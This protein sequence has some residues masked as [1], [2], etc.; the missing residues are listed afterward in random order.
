MRHLAL[1]TA[2]LLTA[3]NETGTAKVD[4]RR[5]PVPG[6]TGGTWVARFG[7]DTITDRELN[8]RFAEMN[9][10]ARARYQTVEQ[11]REYV[12]GLVR[13]ELLSQEAVRQGLANDPEVVETAKR[14]MV[15][16]LLKKEIEGNASQVTD[17]QVAEYYQ[18]H[19]SDYVKPAMT[20]L[21]H[22]FFTKEHR[23]QAEEVLAQVKALAPLDYAAFAKLAR[24]RSEDPR[25]RELDG[26]LRFLADEELA[27]QYGDALVKAAA[28]LQKVGD[29]APDLVETDKGFHIVKLQGRQIALNLS[30]EQARPSIQQVLLNE[31]RQDRFRALLERLKKQAH[32]E[33]NE[34]ALAAIVVDPKAPAAAP[35]SP[36]PG[37][38]AAPPPPPSR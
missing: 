33:V 23:A 21:S 11:R 12:D 16:L 4:F 2:L 31:T 37:F 18:A 20:R 6:A 5:R 8:Q 9:P 27:K 25:S 13:F 32:F 19:Q 3:C 28:A 17:A 38:I 10:Y 26:D 22:I 34:S 36:Q 29:V 14:V 15:Q 35:S 24:E 1:V 30:L 7:G